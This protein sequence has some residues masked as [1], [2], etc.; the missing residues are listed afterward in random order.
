[1]RFLPLRKGKSGTERGSDDE[2]LEEQYIVVIGGGEGPRGEEKPSG[3]RKGDVIFRL[4]VSGGE[5]S[6][7]QKEKAESY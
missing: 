4:G 3:Y 7:G 6:R 1:V 2:R 5:G